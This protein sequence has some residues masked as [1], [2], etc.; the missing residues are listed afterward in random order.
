MEVELKS[1]GDNRMLN[2]AV[3]ITVVL[4]SVFM[5]VTKIKDDNIVQAMQAAKADAL[6]TWNEYQAERLKLRIAQQ[7]LMADARQS[8]L[9]D[10]I[11]HYTKE[12]AG[13]AAKAKAFETTYDTLNFQDDQFDLSDASLAISLSLAAVATLTSLWWLLG[14]SWVFAFFG[15]LMG[16]AGFCGWNIHPAWLVSLFT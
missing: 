3:A 6:D 4:L 12:A 15:L 10:D 9:A 16:A 1:A 14:V 2:T 7:A 5:A 11:A 13:L 8:Q